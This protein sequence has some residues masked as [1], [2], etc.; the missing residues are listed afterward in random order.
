MSFPHT[1]SHAIKIL[2]HH[3]QKRLNMHN[4]KW[5][6]QFNKVNLYAERKTKNSRRF[7]IKAESEEH[8]YYLS[9]LE[10]LRAKKRITGFKAGSFRSNNKRIYKL[11]PRFVRLR[12]LRLVL[13]LF[14][15][16]NR[17]RKFRPYIYTGNCQKSLS[18][19]FV[20]GKDPNF[21][22]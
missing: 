13:K 22:F 2:D 9:S 15:I 17:P 19:T 7:R 8:Y 12:N 18:F 10:A 16:T 20:T 21:E 6:N 3:P 5:N 4:N 11:V 14:S 1:D